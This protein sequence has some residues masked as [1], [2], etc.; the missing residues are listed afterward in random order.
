MNN[1]VNKIDFAV[2]GQ[3]VLEGVMMRSPN[4]YTVCVRDEQGKIHTKQKKFASVIE[5][6]KY[7]NVPIIRGV[8]HM[9]ESMI[10]G[11][12]SL[13]LSNEILIKESTEE[14]AS[15]G[16]LTEII[17]GIF[18]LLTVVF[19]VSIAIFML[20][21]IPL[22]IAEFASNNFAFI[23][24]NYFAFNFIDGVSKISIFILYILFLSTFKDIRRVFQYH[25]AEHKAIWTY[26]LGLELTV[27]NAKKQTRF[28][29][30][31]GT[32]FI[33]IVIL[34]SVVIYTIMPNSES[35]LDK[36]F[37]RIAVIPLIAGTSY[38]LLK[39]SAKFQKNACIKAFVAPGLFIQKLTTKEPD[40]DQLFVALSSLKESLK[41]E[42]NLNISKNS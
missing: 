25:G 32:S 6:Y 9:A 39:L 7:L 24:S 5:K 27:E 40:E 20:K 31:C 28:H 36:L 30:R 41:A 42:S 38:E 34:M 1:I 11:Y 14:K 23:E 33:F 15:S 3:A 26:E 18:S 22:W 13:D 21:I 4:F 19:S 37:T 17:F 35:F 10:L 8:I 12:K 2:G 29:P 16:K